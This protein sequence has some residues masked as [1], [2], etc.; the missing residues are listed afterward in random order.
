MSEEASYALRRIP[1]S[2]VEKAADQLGPGTS[3]C[4]LSTPLTSPTSLADCVLAPDTDQVCRRIKS[5]EILI[6]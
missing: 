6:I 5:Y 2:A 4:L 3:T 1:L